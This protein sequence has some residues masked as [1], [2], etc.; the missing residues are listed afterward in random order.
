MC[1]MCIWLCILWSN[2][3]INCY[4]ILS[5]LICDHNANNT[6]SFHVAHQNKKVIFITNIVIVFIWLVLSLIHWMWRTINWP[7][8]AVQ[9]PTWATLE[10]CIRWNVSEEVQWPRDNVNSLQNMW[11]KDRF[12]NL[13]LNI[14][15]Y[16]YREFLFK[17]LHT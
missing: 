13:Y 12:K 9:A 3:K 17:F 2:L 10:D 6:E 4:L 15:L 8:E 11:L 16:F 1:I 7:A 14:Y 5:L